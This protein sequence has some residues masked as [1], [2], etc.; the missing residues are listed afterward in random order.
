MCTHDLKRWIP[1]AATGAKARIRAR[2]V[3]IACNAV[4]LLFSALGSFVRGASL[5]TL[6]A[7]QVSQ[8]PYRGE[9]VLEGFKASLSWYGFGLW[10]NEARR[11]RFRCTYIRQVIRYDLGGATKAHKQ[12]ADKSQHCGQ[13]S[14]PIDEGA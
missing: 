8:L 6:P 5:A 10:V 9:G 3:S 1:Y 11:Q 2:L 14:N 13:P 7:R 4:L 12:D